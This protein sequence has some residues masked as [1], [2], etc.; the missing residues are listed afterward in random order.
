ERYYNIKREILNLP[1]L[2]I[3]DMF[4]PVGKSPKKFTF[5]EALQLILRTAER[6]DERFK[7][8]IEE[9]V[10]L[11]HLDIFPRKG[12][13]TNAFCS[14]GKRKHYPFVL[15]N[16]TDD[17]GGI[18]ELAHELG[19]AFHRYYY[20][21]NQNFLN[22]GTTIVIMEM[23]AIFMELLTLNQTL[24]LDL[25]K[26][27]KIAFLCQFI[28]TIF[29]ST[30]RQNAFHL[31]EKRIHKLI[32]EK[33][34]SMKEFNDIFTEEIQRMYRGSIQK[35][36]DDYSH[37]QFVVEQFYTP[38]FVY[39]YNMSYMI[40][41]A[42]FQIY[43]EKGREFF[44]QRYINLLSTGFSKSPAEMLGEFGID[45]RD[46]DFWQKGFDYISEQVDYLKEIILNKSN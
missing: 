37:F 18:W 10:K 21:L 4:A 38:F 40:V 3:Y 33:F 46:P 35:I 41:I 5:D 8:I 28:E 9:M 26:E 32:E 36:R 31:F 17:I 12:K 13:H 45:L 24:E 29:H 39:S 14:H 7:K 25:F 1:E 42:L 20:Q 43:K 16:F 15:M 11:K 19:H 2:R 22:V 34:L 44:N 30:F 23:A 27:D 6:F